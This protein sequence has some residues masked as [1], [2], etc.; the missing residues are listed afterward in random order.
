MLTAVV[1]S[2]SFL[3]SYLVHHYQVGS[4]K[5]VGPAWLRLV[6]LGV[7]VPH[8][9]LSAV[10]V[11]LVLWTL[12]R[13]LRRDFPGH[14]KI[15]RKTLPVWLVVSVTGVMVYWMLYHLSPYLQ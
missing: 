1:L 9:V 11:P 2:A 10:M 13:A 14:R 8:V 15:A 6:Y 4:V 3:A 7:L 5:F 12:L